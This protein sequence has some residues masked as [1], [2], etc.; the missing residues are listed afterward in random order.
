MTAE[1]RKGNDYPLEDL[2][3]IYG[4]CTTYVSANDIER[5]R[6]ELTPEDFAELSGKLG[7]TVQEGTSHAS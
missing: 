4:Q 5:L 3:E 7:W 6:S 1:K 2:L